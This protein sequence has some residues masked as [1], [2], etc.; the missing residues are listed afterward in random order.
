MAGTFYVFV[1]T[2]SD[3]HGLRAESGRQLRL[4]SADRADQPAAARRPGGGH[5]H[6]PG[7]R[8]GGP[9]H[10]HHLP[11]DQRRHSPAN[12]SWYDSLY[13]SPTP[14]WSVTDP[15]LGTV[16]QT[17]D[18]APGSSYTGTLTAPLPG[19]TPGSYYVILRTNILD[20]FPEPTLDQQPE[21]IA[22]ARRP[23]TPGPDAGHRRPVATLANGQSAYYKVTVAAGQTLQVSLAASSLDDAPPPA[24]GA[25]PTRTRMRP[26]SCTSAS[27][28][29]RP[30]ASSTTAPARS[31]EPTSRSPFPRRRRELITSWPTASVAASR[32][33][34]L[35]DI[36]YNY[37]LTARSFR[38]R[39]RRSAR[40]RSAPAGHDRDRR[41]EVR[42]RHHVPVC[43][44]PTTPSSTTRPSSC[45]TAAR[46][47][48]TFDLTGMPTGTYTVQ[49]TQADGTTTQLAAGADR[50]PGHAGQRA[51]P[52]LAC[53]SAVLPGSG[54][55]R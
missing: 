50:R 1:E 13:L 46:R 16:H 27:A 31:C 44:G 17:Q 26:T 35:R 25:R 12:G 51:G 18:L 2:N 45:K 9:G 5:G 34:R 54:R 20:N 11:G 15:L 36:S 33:P 55:A 10:H 37:T 14:T 4:R 32:S 48:V 21:R 41:L 53:P 42:Q 22:D 3:E 40:A 7:Q 8:R 30:W 29:C 43:S 49:A 6:D 19:V 52:P 38:S 24:P 39:S 23:S 47:F 28:P